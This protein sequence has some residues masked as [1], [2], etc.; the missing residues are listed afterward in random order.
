MPFQG[1][2]RQINSV[3]VMSETVSGHYFS[4]FFTFTCIVI[5]SWEIKRNFEYKQ[6]LHYDKNADYDDDDDESLCV[7]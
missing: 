1:D 7:S 3:Q 4:A 6:C 2:L 5:F